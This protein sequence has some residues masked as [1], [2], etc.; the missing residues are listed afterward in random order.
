MELDISR[1]LIFF[2]NNGNYGNCKDNHNKPK[3][4]DYN[5]NDNY[6]MIRTVIEIKVIKRLKHSYKDK[7]KNINQSGRQC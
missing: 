7:I 4:N 6:L 5:D 3:G 1:V 2:F